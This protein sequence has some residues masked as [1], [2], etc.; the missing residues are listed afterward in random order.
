M[1]E[2]EVVKLDV[3]TPDGTLHVEVV[4]EG[5]PLLY[6]HG[7]TGFGSVAQQEAPAGFRVATYDQ[8]GHGGGPAP[9]RPGAF[10]L[11]E[12]VA[13][14]L[15][16]L[17]ALAAHESDGGWDQ[18]AVGGT[19]MG[20]AVALE[21][22]HIHPGR[23]G[24]LLLTGPAFGD[25][26][27]PLSERFPLTADGIEQVGIDAAIPLIRDAQIARGIPIEATKSLDDWV[28]HPQRSFPALLRTVAQWEPYPEL[29]RLAHLGVPVSIVAW[30]DDEVHPLELAERLRALLGARFETLEGVGQV[31]TEPTAVGRAHQA[32]RAQRV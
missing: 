9:T 32:A 12:F 26:P 29:D 6:L 7:L 15:A 13:D 4:G 21:L 20:A 27:N 18:A 31:L 16:V 25:A 28:R 23:V 19:S 10:G 17:D 2:G 8:R 1:A 3:A 22:A 24:E 30:P 14:A 11:S 5:A